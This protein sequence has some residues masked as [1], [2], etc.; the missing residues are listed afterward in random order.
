M[1]V[2]GDWKD[3]HWSGITL[4]MQH[5]DTMAPES[6]LGKAGDEYNLVRMWHLYVIVDVF[7]SAGLECV[8]Q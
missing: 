6:E 7:R 3:N 4:A 1:S 8:L 5:R 2:F